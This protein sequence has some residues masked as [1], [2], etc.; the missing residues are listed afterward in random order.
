M[1]DWDMLRK[2]FDEL[3]HEYS[4]QMGSASE[5]MMNAFGDT[6]TITKELDNFRIVFAKTE[7]LFEL[8]TILCRLSNEEMKNDPVK[9]CKLDITQVN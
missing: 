1:M 7:A 4:E 3:N 8:H 2:A 5:N 9:D 6:G